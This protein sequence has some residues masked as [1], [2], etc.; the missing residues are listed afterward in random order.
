VLYDGESAEVKIRADK[1]GEVR[2]ADVQ[3]GPEVRVVNHDLLIATL[4]E[5]VPLNIDMRVQKGRGYRTAEENCEGDN[6]I[7]VIWVDSAFSP[8]SRVRYKTE[9]TRV[10]Q[11]TNYDRLILEIWTNGTLA[12]E[13]ALVEAA[14]ILRKHLNP[15]VQYAD[16]GQ[17]LQC[18]SGLS[19]EDNVLVVD[20]EE[21]QRK[22]EMPVSTL[23]LSVR[24]QNCLEGQAVKTVGDLVRR[25]ESDLLKVRN[26]GKTTLLE[27]KTKLRDFGLA[28]GMEASTEQTTPQTTQQP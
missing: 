3:H 17:V 13:L 23:D 24:A 18:D 15:F 4:T 11:L 26:F 27:I 19:T 7:G 8:V 22:L 21:K 6:E 14:K 10:G 25:S 20:Q 5:D 9:D 28:L 12:P 1:K 16:I 2:A